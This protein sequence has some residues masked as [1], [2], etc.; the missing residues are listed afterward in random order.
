MWKLWQWFTNQHYYWAFVTLSSKRIR[1][2][3]NLLDFA[4]LDHP[5]TKLSPELQIP[6]VCLLSVLI[7][8]SYFWK[9]T[10]HLSPIFPS[11]P[12]HIPNC[13]QGL[14]LTVV[15]FSGFHSSA[16]PLPSPT[17]KIVVKLAAL[18]LISILLPCGHCPCLCSWVETLILQSVLPFTSTLLSP[19]PTLQ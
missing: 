13:T 14:L 4:C 3:P 17:S 16:S 10:D 8:R 19:S 5:E 12:F 9:Q 2:G 7:S 6:P 1:W 11:R 15:W 18:Q